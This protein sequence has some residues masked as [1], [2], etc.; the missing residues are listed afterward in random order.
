[1]IASKVL[2]LEGRLL[3]MNE[4]GMQALLSC[5]PSWVSSG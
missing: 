3:S 4:G 1:M 2:D 5:R